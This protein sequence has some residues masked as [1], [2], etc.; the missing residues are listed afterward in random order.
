[1]NL[2]A[3]DRI[4]TSVLALEKECQHV[5]VRCGKAQAEPQMALTEH[6]DNAIAVYVVD[7]FQYTRIQQTSYQSIAPSPSPFPIIFLAATFAPSPF[8]K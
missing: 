2:V 4:M 3:K 1:M 6:S 5:R 7:F 8:G